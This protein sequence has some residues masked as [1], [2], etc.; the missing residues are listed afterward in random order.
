MGGGCRLTRVSEFRRVM[1]TAARVPDDKDED[2]DPV[3]TDPSAGAAA[4]AF[5][6]L[7]PT[8]VCSSWNNC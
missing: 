4:A 8:M 2:M 1:E 5:L 3:Q 7:H 6:F